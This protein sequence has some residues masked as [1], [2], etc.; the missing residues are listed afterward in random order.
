[1][2]TKSNL[3][4]AVLAFVAILST[5][6][7]PM[8][9]AQDVTTLLK[10]GDTLDAAMKTKQALEAYKAALEL[11]PT[12]SEVLRKIAKQYAELIID[13]SS[14]SEKLSLAK[15]SVEYAEKSIDAPGNDANSRVALAICLAK[16]GDL[17]DNKTK[18]TLSRRIK[19]LGTEALKLDPNNELAFHVLGRWH[20]EVS[21]MNPF[22]KGIAKIIYGDIP[23][24]SLDTA[25]ENFRKATALNPGRVSNQIE[26]GRVLLLAGKK[27]EGRKFLERGLAMADTNRDDPETKERGRLTL[28]EKG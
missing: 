19:K 26:L 20:A 12:N 8:S 9:V 6:L 2:K 16:I 3:Y 11:A 14:T 28:K 13:A 21:Q 23:P 10:E 22:V 15:T 1:M 7:P 25:I 17:S 4:L 18:V 24:A 5:G 27:E